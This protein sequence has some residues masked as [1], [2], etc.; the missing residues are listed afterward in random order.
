[1]KPIKIKNIA[2]AVSGT[3]VWGDGEAEVT[4]VVTDSREAGAGVLFVPIIG[5]RVD[6]HRF[7]P[8]VLEKGAACVFSAQAADTEAYSHDAKGACIY[9]KDTLRAL[10]DFAGWYR[11]QF[12]L[13]V[14]GITGSVGKTTTKEMIGAVL[15]RKYETLKTIRNLNSQ[16][17]VALMMFHLEETTEMAVF[18]MGISMPG[19]MDRLVEIAKPS[20]AVMTNI[21]VSHIGNLGSRENICAEKGKILMRFGKDGRL[22]VC[23]NGDL[24]ELSKANIPYGKCQGNCETI[25]YG[26]E[27][28][29]LY[30]G[31]NIH[32]DGTGQTFTFHYP[33]GEEEIELSVMGAHN[34]NNAIV[35]LAL[36]LQYD[37]PLSEAKKALKAYQPIAMR[38]VVKEV[39]G[40]HIIDDT[41]NASPDSV[42][43]N[44]DALFDYS[45]KGKKVAVLAD[46]LELG[47]RSRELHEEMG[48]FILAEMEKGKKL[49][50]LVTV[51]EMAEYISR[52]VA[53]RT[54]IPVIHCRDNKAAAEAVR[55]HMTAGDWIL[56]KGSRG[57][58]M[59]EVVEQ[60]TKE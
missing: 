30:Y 45:G 46:V 38:G 2:E 43:S 28:D 55:K 56:V 23:G 17:G 13:P 22:Y 7:I 26:T 1:M 33:E 32:T 11:A 37:V 15:E 36:A 21:G 8:E 10:Q 41:Y 20:T 53:N 49:S 44:L 12:A 6:A 40:V 54:D 5:E 14:I 50:L 35:A 39:A 27:K 57:M 4:S 48:A 52:Y 9:V 19:E 42:N 25:Y 51:G 18:E 31:D 29:C 3:L 59:D 60:L 58:H 24:K 16:I 47:E 34:V